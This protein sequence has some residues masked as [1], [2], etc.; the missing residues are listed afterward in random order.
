MKLQLTL[1]LLS[2]LL[3]LPP[4]GQAESILSLPEKGKTSISDKEVAVTKEGIHIKVQDLSLSEL[5][6]YIQN[7][8]GIHFSIPNKLR[9]EHI[10]ANFK[11]KDWK[12]AISKILK[13]YNRAEILDQQN[14]LQRV[15][16]LGKGNEKDIPPIKNAVFVKKIKT[17]A[18]DEDDMIQEDPGTMDG[19]PGVSIKEQY[20]PGPQMDS[21]YPAGSEPPDDETQP[22]EPGPEKRTN[23]GDGPPGN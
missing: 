12:A 9:E 6:Q 1:L 16:V 22:Y 11:A 5:L 10:T 14:H 17:Q 19:P 8:S 21:F 18:P 20:F 4:S 13:E 3:C 15:L 7:K 2:T 23:S